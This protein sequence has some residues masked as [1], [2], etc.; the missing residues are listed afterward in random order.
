MC[1][2][3]YVGLY[4]CCENR[5]LV[6]VPFRW[7]VYFSIHHHTSHSATL[8]PA[9]GSG[10][11][12]NLSPSFTILSPASLGTDSD[13]SQFVADIF[14]PPG[15]WPSSSSSSTRQPFHHRFRY[16]AVLHSHSTNRPTDHSCL[17]NNRLSIVIPELL[18]RPHS[19]VTSRIYRSVDIARQHL[20][21]PLS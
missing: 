5:I 1:W 10:L 12:H 9:K 18:I 8:Q 20:T 6:I 7:Q 19:P 15:P 14:L 4:L 17:V 13:P 11:K 16:P 21:L 3:I 2:N